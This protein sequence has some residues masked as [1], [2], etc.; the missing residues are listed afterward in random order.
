MSPAQVLHDAGH[1]DAHKER[2][3][4]NGRCG[5]PFHCCYVWLRVDERDR[6]PQRAIRGVDSF[7]TDPATKQAMTNNPTGR[8][9]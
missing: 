6:Y 8:T 1:T 4:F 5:S 7:W 2:W 9:P 3:V